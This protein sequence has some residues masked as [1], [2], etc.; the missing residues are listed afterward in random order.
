M[1][2]VAPGGSDGVAAGPPRNCLRGRGDNYHPSF[3]ADKNVSALKSPGSRWDH[4]MGSRF[5]WGTILTWTQASLSHH[6]LKGTPGKE[7][8]AAKTS[9]GCFIMFAQEADCPF[10]TPATWTQIPCLYWEPT[11]CIDNSDHTVRCERKKTGQKEGDSHW[12]PWVSG[13]FGPKWQG[14]LWGAV[15]QPRV[16]SSAGSMCSKIWG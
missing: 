8:K 1:G 5:G 9:R 3:T 10:S 13:K 16:P 14:H 12:V 11:V 6:Q 15:Q 7:G 4:S 2:I